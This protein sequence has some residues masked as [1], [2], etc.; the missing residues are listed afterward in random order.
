MNFDPLL[1]DEEFC[2]LI[3]YKVLN[4]DTGTLVPCAF[5]DWHSLSQSL[6]SHV[7]V[8]LD[9]YVAGECKSNCEVQ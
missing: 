6:S 8:I 9:A 4:S 2:L 3:C 5:R 7:K 1:T